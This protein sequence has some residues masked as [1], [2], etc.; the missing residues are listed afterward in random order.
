MLMANKVAK[1][2][3]RGLAVENCVIVKS[4]LS[5]FWNKYSFC[6]VP[7]CLAIWCQKQG[8]QPVTGSFLLVSYHGTKIAKYRFQVAGCQAHVFAKSR[9]VTNNNYRYID[10]T[11]GL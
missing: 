2:S 5:Y 4:L 8:S 9:G 6:A 3:T 1:L 10:N 7:R 11:V